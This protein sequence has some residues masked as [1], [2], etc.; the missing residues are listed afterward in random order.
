MCA[1]QFIYIFG[2]DQIANL[3]TCIDPVHGLASESVPE[4]DASV[5][6][7]TSTAHCAMLMGRPSNSFHCCNMISELYK[8]LGWIRLVPDHQFII[9][10][11]RG[12]LLLIWAPFE[13]AYFLLVTL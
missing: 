4:A 3:T 13:T 1:Y 5:C 11:S 12:E 10:T 8:W 7:T 9:V 6:C 2:I